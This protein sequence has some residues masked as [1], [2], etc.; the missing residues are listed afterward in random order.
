MNL[1]ITIVRKGNEWAVVTLPEVPFSKQ[2][3]AFKTIYKDFLEEYDEIQ[4]WS[5]SSGRV[6]RR[7]RKLTVAAP[8]TTGATDQPVETGAAESAETDKAAPAKKSKASKAQTN[9]E[10]SV[11]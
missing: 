4:V 3:R 2:R 11:L 10:T 5:S 8:A 6:L 1:G 7:K 9:Q